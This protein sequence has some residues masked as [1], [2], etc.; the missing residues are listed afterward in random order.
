MMSRG[1]AVGE[2]SYSFT[3][4]FPGFVQEVVALQ[5]L[6]ASYDCLLSRT[7]PPSSVFTEESLAA[8][9]KPDENSQ[10]RVAWAFSSR[11]R[12]FSSLL[13]LFFCFAWS[14]FASFL[15]FPCPFVKSCWFVH[16][17]SM[18]VPCDCHGLAKLLHPAEA[19]AFMALIRFYTEA[20]KPEKA[21]ELYDSLVHKADT[22]RS[23]S[24]VFRHVHWVYC[25][26][27]VDRLGKGFF[28]VLFFG[29][30]LCFLFIDMRLLEFSHS[31]AGWW[32]AVPPQHYRLM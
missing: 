7:W 15:N 11:V 29:K 32:E 30:V 23:S 24:K 9:L 17:C 6:I 12:F 1:N 3:G 31:R 22:V 8:L 18:F 27:T 16:V 14:C 21:L 4:H 2:C 10:A 25:Q 26:Y 13:V 5:N 28:D 20:G 19:P